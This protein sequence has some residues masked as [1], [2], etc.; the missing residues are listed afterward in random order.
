MMDI[1]K[2]FKQA[3]AKGIE[4]IQI[5]L[6]NSTNLSITIYEGDVDKYE[7]ADNSKLIVKGIFNKK[8]GVYS[9][10]VM[11]NDLIDEILDTIIESAKV[12]DSEDDAIIYEGDKEYTK[13]EG[14]FNEDLAK[15]DVSKKI[16]L[17]KT[18]DTKF[19]KYDERI[20]HVETSYTEITNSFIL[21]NSKGLN[22]EN[23]ANSSY[24]VGE[25]IVSDGLDQ[26]TGFDAKIT[27]D[28][29]DYNVDEFVKEISDDALNS[30]GA[31]SVVSKN[32]EIL[33][34]SLSLAT[35]FSAFQN[36][37][38]ANAVQKGL[39]L[40]KDK[41]EQSV[42]SDLVNVI[43]DPFMKKSASSRSFDDE[44]VATKRKYLIEKGVL[45]TYLH[46]LVTAKKD[47]V[48]STGNGFGGGISAVNLKV[49]AGETSFE[50]MVKS[51]KD[52]LYI[53]NVQGAHAGAN[54][55]SGDFSLQAAG[56]HI[57]DGKIVS[58]VALI[59][60]A[61]NFL[62][63]LKDVVMVGNKTKMTYFGITCPPVKIN[64]MIVSGK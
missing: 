46:N 50:D 61:G 45:K 39:S 33:F 49:E 24:V 53:T 64:S 21:R 40:L 48:N 22:L 42:G 38:S 5:S 2:L 14:L 60:V 29:N 10:E 19:H 6:S 17:L 18:L 20:K 3:K 9:T 15:L 37:F 23:K 7:I 59:T 4:D 54:P 62:T 8:M 63:M 13:V 27:N 57:V 36:V 58:P 11:E 52:G 31:D 47:G 34:S 44:G 56:Y 12:I 43:D 35:L 55:V 16:D 1:D 30:L 25:V 26:R 51:I 32:Y 28:F 41:L